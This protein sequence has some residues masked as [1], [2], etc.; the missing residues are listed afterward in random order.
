MGLILHPEW[1]ANLDSAC[2]L[3]DKKLKG[4]FCHYD[5]FDTFASLLEKVRNAIN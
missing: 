2:I 1:L 3:L 4:T 5:N